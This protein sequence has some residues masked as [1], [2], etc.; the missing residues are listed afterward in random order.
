MV[1]TVRGIRASGTYRTGRT[2]WPVVAD[3]YTMR[4]VAG[5]GRNDH[6]M[7]VDAATTKRAQ[8][9]ARIASAAVRATRRRRRAASRQ[10]LRR[11]R[12]S[13]RAAEDA[14]EGVGRGVLVPMIGMLT[15][16]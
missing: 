7:E 3:R 13:R 16:L 15:R 8:C 10:R 2:A 14:A 4:K 12:G 9:A 11:T 5:G 6:A 1:L